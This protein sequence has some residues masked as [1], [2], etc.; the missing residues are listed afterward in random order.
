[1]ARV[2]LPLPHP[3]SHREWG[4][5]DDCRYRLPV[6]VG[7]G[8]GGRWSPRAASPPA[9][10]RAV[11]R[12]SLNRCAEGEA[13]DRV[14]GS[15]VRWIERHDEARGGSRH[16]RRQG[17]AARLASLKTSLPEGE[18]GTVA[19]ETAGIAVPRTWGNRGA[20]GA[21]CRRVPAHSA[22]CPGL[23]PGFPLHGVRP[24]IRSGRVRFSG[25][26]LHMTARRFRD[27]VVV[28]GGVARL[29]S[30]PAPLPRGE[31][32][33]PGSGGRSVWWGGGAGGG[34][35]GCM[36][37]FR[38]LLHDENPPA[39]SPRTGA[40]QHH[41]WGPGAGPVARRGRGCVPGRIR[42]VT[43]T[44]SPRTRNSASRDWRS[45]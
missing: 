16:W 20:T 3:L 36:P 40:P 33:R 7:G 19:L 38:Y 5:Q 31:G 2:A 17:L 30:P 21:A 26:V 41:R 29:A 11:S 12:W 8:S 22:H 43:G 37:F 6:P 35:A 32:R 13:P 28:R 34:G 39:Q 23:G 15:A 4:A 24:R 45:G 9:P 14:R 42:R 44:R 27:Q 18:E 25:L 1:M 10:L